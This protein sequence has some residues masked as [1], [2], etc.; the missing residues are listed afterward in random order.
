VSWPAVLVVA[1]AVAVTVLSAYLLATWPPEPPPPTAQPE[2]ATGTSEAAPAED[3]E[4]PEAADE[5]VMVVLGDSFSA[6]STESAGPEWPM[7]LGE[8]F[9][10]EVR[11][12]AVAGSGY[13]SAG[14]GRPFGARV[15]AVVGHSPD[16]IFVAGGVSD[17]G[18]HP[19]GRIVAAA[20]DVVSRLVA[21]APDAQV[22]VVSPFS[23]GEPGPLTEQ[24]SA[25]LQ[26]IAQDHGAAYVDASRWLVNGTGLFGA[27]VD[28]PADAGQGRIADRMERELTERGIASGEQ[29]NS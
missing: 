14:S 9:G 26:Q 8:S 29:T 1:A 21:E 17:L 2:R 25:R 22:V 11:T 28:Q 27:E 15:P 5:T 6:E 4:E 24:F 18:A 19:I 16:V 12:E 23:N 10:W 13:V 20:D 7:L 3:S